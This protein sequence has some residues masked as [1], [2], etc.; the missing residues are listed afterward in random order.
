M[1]SRERFDLSLLRIGG[2]HSITVEL[3]RLLPLMLA[4]RGAIFDLSGVVAD[5][6]GVSASSGTSDDEPKD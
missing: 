5:S 4:P 2:G 1:L 3:Y 6:E